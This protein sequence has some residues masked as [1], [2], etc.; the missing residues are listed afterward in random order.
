MSN[1]S[2]ECWSHAQAYTP[3]DD[4]PFPFTSRGVYV[5]STGDLHVTM[6]SGAETTFVA[7]AAGIVL[8]W[9][10]VRIFEDSTA[11]DIQIGY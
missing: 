8:P 10:V 6:A 7:V 5:G 1:E 11:G 3:D 9:T 4:T 2:I